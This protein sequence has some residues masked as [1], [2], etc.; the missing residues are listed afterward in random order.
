MKRLLVLGAGTACTM[1]V[2]KLRRRLDDE[3]E[4]TVVEK[5]DL[6]YYQP[7]YL[8]FPFGTYAPG[9]VV[10]PTR[11]FI[12]DGVELV[13]AEIDRVLHD[14]NVVLLQD[15]RRLS[16]DYLIATGTQPRP[17]QTEG[18]L[19]GGQWRE[20][21]HEFYTFEGRPRAAGEGP[22]RARRTAPGPIVNR[23]TVGNMTR[24]PSRSVNAPT[25]MRPRDPT[26][27][28]TATRNACWKA[29]RSRSSRKA[30]PRGLISAQAQKFTGNPAV[31]SASIRPAGAGRP[32]GVG[33][34]Q[35]GLDG[36]GLLTLPFSTRNASV[37][38]TYGE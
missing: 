11:R 12:P 13:H 2:N 5:S 22:R 6:H 7:G 32:R 4:V 16:Y 28:R 24:A 36:S 19:D 18:V 10:K 31:A 3:W 14:E 8:F 34:G 35:V 15:G 37:T 29:L 33:N 23:L 38:S 17:D 27:T 20:S 26:T 21:I 1:V 25:G 9:D 30:A